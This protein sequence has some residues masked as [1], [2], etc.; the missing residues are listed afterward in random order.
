MEKDKFAEL[1]EAHKNGVV[2]QY[3]S[4]VDGEWCTVKNDIDL[5]HD[6]YEY[7]IKPE[8][9]SYDD[10]Y[11]WGSIVIDTD[12]YR[13]NTLENSSKEYSMKTDI[14]VQNVVKKYQERSEV[15]IKKYNTT[16]QENSDGVEVFLNHLQEEL[17]DA[18]LY[19]EKLKQQVKQLKDII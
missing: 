14:I 9:E 4:R 12:N 5:W 16:L 8:E 2:I 6:V 15:G 19:I 7:R 10:P 11:N 1:K 18:T 3:K 13:N 17:M